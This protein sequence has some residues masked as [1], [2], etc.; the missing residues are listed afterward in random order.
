MG[1]V[2]YTKEDYD[3]MASK[4]R[5]AFCHIARNLGKAHPLVE[6]MGPLAWGRNPFE[7]G[8]DWNLRTAVWEMS[9]L[10]GM[11]HILSIWARDNDPHAQ[12]TMLTLYPRGFESSKRK[13]QDEPS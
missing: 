10:D 7:Q 2:N 13:A 12:R 3:L 8:P 11:F 6:L 4:R 5:N 1:N 9:A